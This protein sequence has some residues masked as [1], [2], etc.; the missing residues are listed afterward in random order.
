M[1]GTNLDSVIVAAWNQTALYV[2]AHPSEFQW[3]DKENRVLLT[4]R[5]RIHEI[6]PQVQVTGPEP[7]RQSRFGRQSIDLVCVLASERVAIEGKFKVVSDGAQPDNRKDAFWDLHKLEQYVANGA[8]SLGFFLWLTDAKQ[9][10]HEPKG[11]S[12][13]FSTHRGRQY[14]GGT[15]L[16]ATRARSHPNGFELT[17]RGSYCFDWQPVTSNL[18]WYRLLIRVDAAT[19]S[20]K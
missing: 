13:D 14:I 19:Q 20:L 6:N 11:D 17:L 10:L 2:A 18:D 8:Y 4:L 3:G 1:S 16:R 9:Y 5:D 12:H 15:T 7:H